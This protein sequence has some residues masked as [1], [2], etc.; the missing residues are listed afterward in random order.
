MEH[1]LEAH[2]RSARTR[3][4]RGELRGGELSALIGAV[5]ALDRDAFVDE[6]LAIPPP[7]PDEPLPAGA[8]PYL[9]CG[10]DDVLAVI[11]ELPIAATDQ[12]VVAGSGLGRVAF[13]IHLLTG[14]TTRGIEIQRGL[15]ERA[16]GLSDELG[17]AVAFDHAN[18]ADVE[19]DGSVVVV[20]APCNGA[21]WTRVVERIAALARRRRI[22]VGA[23]GIELEVPGLRARSSSRAAVVLYDGAIVPG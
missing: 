5:P 13:L 16:R 10:V 15:V 4:A 18:L 19:L 2:A 8:V 14:A 1:S 23:V 3:I 11:R 22:A 20:Y 12:V 7:P 6:L 17:L 21:L 9:P